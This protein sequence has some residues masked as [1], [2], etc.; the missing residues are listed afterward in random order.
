MSEAPLSDFDVTEEEAAAVDAV[1]AVVGKPILEQ[2]PERKL[3]EMKSLAAATRNL[4][5]RQRLYLRYLL[6]SQMRPKVALRKFNENF[7]NEPLKES[8]VR[9]W[10]RRRNHFSSVLD[11]YT[12]LMLEQSG[13]GNPARILLRID[14][15]VEDALT[16]VPVLH[17]GLPVFNPDRPGEILKE[18]D[19]GSALKGLEMLGKAAGAFRKDEENSQ[20]VTVVLDFSGEQM[21][22]EQESEVIDGEFVEVKK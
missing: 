13:V 8:T 19:R 3:A 16:P 9:D 2:S 15:V 12:Q 21:Q 1:S 18:V 10:H 20:R 4:T 7:S 5:L 6:G 14:G 22:G 17:Q 11:R